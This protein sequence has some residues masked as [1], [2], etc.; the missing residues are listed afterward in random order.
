M[1][2]GNILNKRMTTI[3]LIEKVRE[4]ERLIKFRLKVPDKIWFDSLDKDSQHDIA[5]SH[6]SSTIFGITIGTYFWNEM[7][8]EHP[9]DLQIERKLKL[10]KILK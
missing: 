7:K 1:I 2:I 6:Y 10:V 8:K 5:R 4:E 9:G 3:N